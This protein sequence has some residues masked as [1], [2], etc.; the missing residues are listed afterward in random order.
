MYSCVLYVHDDNMQGY[1]ITSHDRLENTKDFKISIFFQTLRT[2]N[3][4]LNNN[5]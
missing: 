1:S 2:Q 4:L 5:C 3:I